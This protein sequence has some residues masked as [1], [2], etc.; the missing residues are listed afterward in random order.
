MAQLRKK[1]RGA[2]SQGLRR[3][4]LSIFLVLTLSLAIFFL[5]RMERPETTLDRQ[6][7][8]FSI[9]KVEG[10]A[11]HPP[12]PRLALIIDDMGYNGGKYNEMMGMGKPMT[13]S[14]LPGAPHAWEVALMVHQRGFE[15]MLHLPMEPKEGE[16]YSMEKDTVLAGMRPEMVQKIL[17]EALKRIPHVRGVNNHMGSKATED[18][19][20]MQALMATLKKE[21]L[22]FI[23]S[24]TSSRSLGP[25]TARRAGVA[26]GRNNRFIDPEKNLPAIKGAIRSAMKKAKREGKAV[27]IGHPHPLTALAIKEMMP[28]IER[29]GI[30][31][32]FASEVVG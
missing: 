31:L 20:L 1:T 27:A 21:G 29:E 18:Q 17:Q 28:E 12:P 16:Q 32:V 26:S 19:E 24:Q 8:R 23:D 4:F 15:V 3:A 7:V 5:L 22:Y 11:A 10:D 13:F 14:V 30:Q 9:P 6:V 2:R 25:E